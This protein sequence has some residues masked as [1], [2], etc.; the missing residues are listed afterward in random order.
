MTIIKSYHY[1]PDV[2]LMGNRSYFGVMLILMRWVSNKTSLFLNM[3]IFVVPTHLIRVK[4]NLYIHVLTAIEYL[5]L[6]INIIT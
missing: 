5:T 2:F 4:K 1:R 3:F 6:E